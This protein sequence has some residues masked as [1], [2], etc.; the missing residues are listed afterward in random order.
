MEHRRSAHAAQVLVRETELGGAGAL[1]G[2]SAWT[3]ALS[4]CRASGSEKELGGAR[5]ALFAPRAPEVANS[6]L[7]EAQALSK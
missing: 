5:G 7:R 3:E 6:A 4:N 1:G 2:N